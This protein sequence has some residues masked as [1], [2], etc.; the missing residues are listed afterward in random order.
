MTKEIETK[1]WNCADWM[2]SNTGDQVEQAM[3]VADRMD[4]STEQ[5]LAY[6]ILMER[7]RCARIAQLE[8]R[9]TGLLMSN[10]PQSSAAWDIRNAINAGVPAP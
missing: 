2:D 9:N 10:P 4:M 7:E 8:L 3:E 5:V 1:A 6:A